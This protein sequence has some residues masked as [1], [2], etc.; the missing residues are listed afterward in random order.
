M[1]TAVMDEI[2]RQRDAELK[3]AVRA[4][5]AGDVKGA[6]EKLGDRITEVKPDNLAGAAAARWLKLSGQERENTGLMAPSHALRSGINAII[7]ERLARDGALHGPRLETERLVSYGYTTAEKSLPENYTAGD[8]VGFHRTY[9]SL[10]VEKGDERLV[11]SVDHGR[12]TVM[13]AGTD[14]ERIAWQPQ[15][16]GGRRG[17]VEVYRGE[18][19]ELCA[20]DRIRWTRNDQGLGLVHSHTAEVQSVA[21]DRVTFRLEDGRVAGIGERRSPATPSRPCLGFDRARIP[22]PDGRQRDRG[23]GGE[24]SA[25]HHAEEFLCRDQPRP[26]QSRAGNGRCR[27]AARAP[28]NGDRGTGLGAGRRRD[29]ARHDAGSGE[30]REARARDST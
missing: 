11:A 9:K 2:M 12:G 17:A 3:E 4:S 29:R 5:L 20:G 6:F 1:K 23:D 21:G 25:P 19:I 18:A 28:G 30:F 26:G 10:E 8:V 22:G 15:R 7:R 27:E 24:P 16:V 14:G 13:L